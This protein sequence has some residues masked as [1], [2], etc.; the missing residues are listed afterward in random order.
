MN[1]D[2]PA[3]PRS[4]AATLVPARAAGA[5]PTHPRADVERSQ[6]LVAERSGLP[7]DW[8]APLDAAADRWDG[9]SDLAAYDAV[10]IAIARNPALR[11]QLEVVAAAR[12]D[13]AQAGLLPNPVL[14]LSLGFPI[15][16]ADGGTS[17]GASLVQNFA[18]FSRGRRVDAAAADLDRVVLELSDHA[19]ALAARTRGCTRGRTCRAGRGVGEENAR[20]SG[21]AADHQPTR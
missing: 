1:R 9:E 3:A 14:S 7:V 21:G 17:V 4:A 16:G 5:A 12:A 13:L 11:A 6:A 2:A 8:L 19:L 18:S 15:A 20:W 10:A